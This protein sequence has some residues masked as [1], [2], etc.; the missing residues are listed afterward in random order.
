L[1]F[2]VSTAAACW[3]CCFGRGDEKMETM[4]LSRWVGYSPP[5]NSKDNVHEDIADDIGKQ[6][7]RKR[8]AHDDRYDWDALLLL[9][10][11]DPVLTTS[12]EPPQLV[13]IKRTTTRWA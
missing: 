7:D 12:L 3:A 10:V 8:A 2:F 11:L 6:H 9:E 4:N 1:V 5:N 13:A